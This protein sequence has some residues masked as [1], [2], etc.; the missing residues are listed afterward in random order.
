MLDGILIIDKPEGISS[1]KTVWKV[2][3]ALHLKKAGHTGTLDPFASGLL[4][5][6]LNQTTKKATY[7]LNLDKTYLG[8][9]ILGIST[10]TQDLTGQ[11]TRICSKEKLRLTREEIERV[12]NQFQGDLWQVPPIYSALKVAGQPLYRLARKGIKILP[13]P[14]KVKIWQLNLLEIRWDRYPS[15]TFK[16]KCSKGTYVRTLCNDIG[17]FL[18]YGA[19]LS[20]LRRVQVGNISL[21]KAIPFNEFII[22]PLEQQKKYILPF[23]TVLEDIKKDTI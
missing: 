9:M 21:K 19:Y 20:D 15:I 1:A 16:V 10:D 3:R 14:R 11:V 13:A 23:N 17:N 18:G 12:F 7:F 5:L 2:K 8:K 4:I 22:L 6:C